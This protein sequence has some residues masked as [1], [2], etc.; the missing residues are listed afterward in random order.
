MRR[1]RILATL[2]P[3]SDGDATIRALIDA[4]ADAFRLNFSHGTPDGHREVCRRIRAAASAARRPVAVMQDLA[5][6]KIRIGPVPAPLVLQEGETLRIESG[7]FDA[8]PG[9]VSCT[10]DALFTSVVPGQHILLD[11]GRIELEVTSVATGAVE[12]RVL[13]GGPLSSH[14][15]INLPGATMRL[16]ALTPKDAEDLRAGL[17]MGVDLVALSFVQ[18]ADDVK[19]ARAVATAAGAPG[20]PIFAK[21]EKPAAVERIDENLAAADGI[22]IARGDLGIELPL[23]TLPTVQT[24]LV[25]A[26]GRFGAPVMVARVVLV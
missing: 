14:K 25:L 15:A 7:A 2:G 18:S 8:E 1:T 5:G 16:S 12:T 24:A 10:A 4:G 19:A 6:P 23:E 22:M 11:D 21:I 26:A 17:E 3:A 20:L 9:R 13:A